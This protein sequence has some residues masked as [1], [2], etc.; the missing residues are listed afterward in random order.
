MSRTSKEEIRHAIFKEVQSKELDQMF[1]GIQTESASLALFS[2]VGD[3]IRFM[4][5]D[6][7]G[8]WD[9]KDGALFDLIVA[10]R[11]SRTTGQA[12]QTILAASLWLGLDRMS[13][14]VEPA[15]DSI[16]DSFSELYYAALRIIH[17]WNME[18]KDK[19]AVNILLGAKKQ[20]IRLYE[21]IR[22][23]ETESLDS[24]DNRE[25][26]SDVFVYQDDFA[27][28]KTV[29]S[30]FEEKNCED[31]LVPMVAAN[32]I[33]SQESMLIVLHDI[34]DYELAEIAEAWGVNYKTLCRK[35]ERALDKLRRHFPNKKDF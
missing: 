9:I 1:Q 29:E 21:S 27:D 6:G 2:D 35:Y 19:I 5:D 4:Q 8:C 11:F 18:K 34:H 3:F 24:S 20:V 23:R 17:S 12:A 31:L 16:Q 10:A 32:V 28:E 26:V 22:K 33:S 15:P 14:L 25:D 30:V 13:K 7:D